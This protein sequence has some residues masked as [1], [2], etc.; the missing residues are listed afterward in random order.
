MHPTTSKTWTLSPGSLQGLQRFHSLL[1]G[2][3]GSL[4]LTQECLLPAVNRAVNIVYLSRTAYD[5]SHLQDDIL[6]SSQAKVTD[7]LFHRLFTNLK[8]TSVRKKQK[9]RNEEERFPKH[10]KHFVSRFS[11]WNIAG[12]NFDLRNRRKGKK[13]NKTL[14]YVPN[15]YWN[16]HILQSFR[17][18]DWIN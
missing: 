13:I 3:A 5:N 9:G 4:Y 1:P 11:K 2:G 6:Q 16:P 10:W 15:K 14:H 12:F 17:I 8:D 18:R 7:Y